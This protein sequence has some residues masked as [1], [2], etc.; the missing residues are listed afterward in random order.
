MKAYVVLMMIFSSVS[1]LFAQQGQTPPGGGFAFG[2]ILP[3]LLVMFVVI[4]F[5]MIRPEQKK[6]KEKQSMLNN[7]KKGD[8]VLT[9]GG[10]HG[11]VGSVK[12]DGVM[13]KVGENT[14]IK[15]S[16]SAISTVFNAKASKEESSA[17]KKNE[18]KGD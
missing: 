5:F 17:D 7:L 11:T 4:Y 6:Q 9:I 3:M 12:D 8:K 1:M 16:R 18:T 2:S 10:I 15:V 14:V 13:L